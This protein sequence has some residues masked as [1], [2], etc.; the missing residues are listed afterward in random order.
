[1]ETLDNGKPFN[2]SIGDIE[3]V[4]EVFQYYAGWC[5]KICGKTIPV[6]KSVP[7]LHYSNKY[8]IIKGRDRGNLKMVIMPPFNEVGV[9]C[10]A[11]VGP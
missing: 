7:L 6:G 3:G 4:V 10:F 2:D 8:N 9:Y 1:M 5:D 11:H